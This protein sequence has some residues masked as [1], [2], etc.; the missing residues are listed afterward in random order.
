MNTPFSKACEIVGAKQLAEILGVTPQAISDWK[1]GKR[2][3]PIDRCAQIEAATN[4]KVCCQ[5]LRP[6][7]GD[8]WEYMRKPGSNPKT[9]RKA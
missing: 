5:E 2:Q 3:I 4:V 6:D 8:F 1:N 9:A 7:K